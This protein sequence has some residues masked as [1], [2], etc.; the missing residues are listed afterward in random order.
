MVERGGKNRGG[1]RE[2]VG[3]EGG[4]KERRKGERGALCC[5][6]KAKRQL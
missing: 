2:T 3:E 6:I 4:M 1:E 5:L